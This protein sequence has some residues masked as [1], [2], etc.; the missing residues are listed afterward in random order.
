M[1]S[2]SIARLLGDRFAKVVRL[3]DD[4]VYRERKV[5]CGNGAGDVRWE[6]GDLNVSCATSQLPV[7]P[8]SRIRWLPR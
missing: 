2:L 8:S 6:G 4:R 3:P 1:E 5:V 7:V